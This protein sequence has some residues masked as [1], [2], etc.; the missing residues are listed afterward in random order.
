LKDLPSTSKIPLQIELLFSSPKS[1]LKPIS[2]LH[3]CED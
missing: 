1:P 3:S 2:E